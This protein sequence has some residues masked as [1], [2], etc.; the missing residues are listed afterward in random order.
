MNNRVSQV[1]KKLETTRTLL[2]AAQEA[3]LKSGSMDVDESTTEK[4]AESTSAAVEAA[5]EQQQTESKEVDTKKLH[6]KLESISSNFDSLKRDQK[7]LFIYVFQQFLRA[8]KSLNSE[9]EDFIQN[10]AWL[11][12]MMREFARWAHSE[13]ATMAFTLDSV[14]FTASNDCDELNQVYS[15]VRCL[16]A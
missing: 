12:G 4:T 13:V 6:E 7:H 10:R 8:F 14:V 9:A 16:H 1:A 5:E 11:M 2:T 3:A 15:T